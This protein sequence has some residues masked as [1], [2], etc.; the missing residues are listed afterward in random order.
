MFQSPSNLLIL[1]FFSSSIENKGNGS[2]VVNYGPPHRLS[3]CIVSWFQQPNTKCYNMCIRAP[4]HFNFEEGW[5]PRD[6]GRVW[7]SFVSLFK[8]NRIIPQ[9]PHQ[10]FVARSSDRCVLFVRR[11]IEARK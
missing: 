2:W 11:E 6:L 4:A 7:G 5:S 9:V 3:Y 10:H 8:R 1:N